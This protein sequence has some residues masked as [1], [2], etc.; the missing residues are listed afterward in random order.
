MENSNTHTENTSP[1]PRPLGFWLRV[2]DGLLAREFATSLD[3]ADVSRRDGMLLNAVD[4]SV[5]APW[6]AERLAR[7][8]GRVRRLADRGWIVQT[9]GV[10]SLTEE[11]R[12]EKE[13]LAGL[14]DG[15]RE[16]VSGAVSPE[17]YATTVDSLE[18]IAR[19]LGWDE[20]AHA[21]RGRGFGPGPRPGSRG[22]GRGFAGGFGPGF[23]GDRDVEPGERGFGPGHRGFGPRH[24]H[25]CGEHRS[26]GERGAHRERAYERGFA[27]GFERGRAAASESVA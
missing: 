24:E 10:W 20:N 17:D 25:G 22:F 27:A 4:G 13:R 2:V 8:S 7:K 1:S 14:V 11:G 21:G 23:T 15:M 6:L 9:D 5:D 26:R 12:A 3:D 18:A 16:R 19:E